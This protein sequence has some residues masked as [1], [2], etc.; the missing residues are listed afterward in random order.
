MDIEY[1]P[2]HYKAVVGYRTNWALHTF[3]PIM[4]TLS[5]VFVIFRIILV[6]HM[7]SNNCCLMHTQIRAQAR[8]YYSGEYKLN[9]LCSIIINLFG[10]ILH[11]GTIAILSISKQRLYHL[12]N[13]VGHFAREMC[14]V[15]EY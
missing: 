12:Q 4:L 2:I 13:V 3:I 9:C 8:D 11:V 7:K 1:R 5:N 14:T 10:S 6:C 15:V